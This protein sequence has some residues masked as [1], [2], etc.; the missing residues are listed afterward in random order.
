MVK[1]SPTHSSGPIGG[2]RGSFRK[3]CAVAGSSSPLRSVP[4]SV[5]VFPESR[6]NVLSHKSSSSVS[7]YRAGLS[8]DQRPLAGRVFLTVSQFHISQA[9]ADQPAAGC[10]GG[11]KE[12]ESN[13][14]AR[15]ATCR[16][17]RLQAIVMSFEVGDFVASLGRLFP[18][19]P[20]AVC[21][22]CVVGSCCIA[23]LM[24]GEV[25]PGFDAVETIKLILTS[26]LPH[27]VLEEL[28]YTQRHADSMLSTTANTRR[29]QS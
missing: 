7:R 20:R 9:E 5:D 23:G 10:A 14:P 13:E 25:S 18:F 26:Y 6:P 27:L 12:A 11:H 8:M 24:Q 16:V 2:G 15:Q 4:S 1:P 3:F 28:L 17:R 22:Y 21:A 19:V 29:P